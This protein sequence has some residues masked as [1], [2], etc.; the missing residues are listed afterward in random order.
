M[1]LPEGEEESHDKKKKKQEG[2]IRSAADPNTEIENVLPRIRDMVLKDRDML[3]KGTKAFTSYIRAY[4]EHQC[5]F[6]FRWVHK[7]A[8]T[9]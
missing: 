1:P 5:A 2:P 7:N 8:L 3:E 6:L 4:K 9:I